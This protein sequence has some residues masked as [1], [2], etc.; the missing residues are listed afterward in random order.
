M[1]TRRQILLGSLATAGGTAGV[2]AASG[3]AVAESYKRGF[4]EAAKLGET[5][6]AKAST[7]W[8]GAH[9]AGIEQRAQSHT[10]FVALDLKS[11]ITKDDMLRWMVLLTDDLANLAEGKPVLADAHPEIIVGPANLSVT[12][13]FGPSLFKKL[14]LEAKMPAGFA[15]LPKFKIDQL[16][17]NFSDGDVL[18]HVGADDQLV[19]AHVT[20]I[21]L[22]DSETFGDVRW[23]QA[24]FTNAVG[25]V[26]EGQTQ[27]NLM[28]QV[29]GTDNPEFGSDNFAKQVWITDGPEWAVG[30]TQL[31]LRR[32]KMNLDTWD[33]LG[34]G[35]KEEVIG[36]K[37]DSGAP[38][39]GTAERDPVDFA[40]KKANGLEVIAP[41][42]HIRRA[43]N[44]NLDERF[45]RRPFNYQASQAEKPGQ[46]E[47]GLLFAAYA[48][49]LAVQFVPVQKRLAE[50]DLLNQWTTPVGSA[51]FAIAGGIA[52][53][54]II[55]EELF[56]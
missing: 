48:K 17:A 27:R 34:R 33:M 14:G 2:A 22:R 51:V 10:N 1:L 15:A 49:N 30:G 38:L 44:T 8:T 50:F 55:A 9:Q 46:L 56:A 3:A 25:S 4:A 11:G 21:L 52:P 39:G 24:G 26:P 53:G 19:L 43:H 20:R 31:V 42:A 36:R 7:K 16:D 29:D 40:A 6:V 41:F 32:I 35:Q 18:L 12:V 28:G 54:Q 13:G 37:L 47:S 23:I 45:F 5:K